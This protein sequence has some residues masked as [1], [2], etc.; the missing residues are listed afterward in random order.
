MRPLV[1]WGRSTLHSGGRPNRRTFAAFPG[2][3][4]CFFRMAGRS[5]C[6]GRTKIPLSTCPLSCQR[7]R[8]QSGVRHPL[9]ARPAAPPLAAWPRH[10]CASFPS[11]QGRHQATGRPMH[12]WAREAR[13]NGTIV[14]DTM[15]TVPFICVQQ[16]PL[17][18]SEPRSTFLQGKGRLRLSSWTTEA[19]MAP[20][21]FAAC[22]SGPRAGT[23]HLTTLI[24]TLPSPPLTTAVLCPPAG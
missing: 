23:T 9:G 5:V 3:M 19:A 17:C 18:Y 1:P 6:L 20:R 24:T 12:Q 21:R 2:R 4:P 10:T 16:C 11:L 7:T 15:P 22:A 8:R 13:D 14:V